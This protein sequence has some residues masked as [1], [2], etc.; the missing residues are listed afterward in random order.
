MS[1]SGPRVLLSLSGTL[2]TPHRRCGVDG[3]KWVSRSRIL[4]LTGKVLSSGGLSVGRFEASF[5]VFGGSDP[6]VS[7]PEE[8]PGTIST[9]VVEK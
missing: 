1:Y 4:S 8:G 3:T 5:V 9:D 6:P 7:V 2:E